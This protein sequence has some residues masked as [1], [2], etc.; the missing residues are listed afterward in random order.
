MSRT[1]KTLP[2]VFLMLILGSLQGLM[3][4]SIDMYLPA[5]P[6]I[7][8]ELAVSAGD[9][10]YTLAIFL[11]GSAIGQLLY[12]PITDA[13]GRKRPL[14]VG[15][16]LYCIG[17]LICASSSTIQALVIGR[18]VQAVGAAAT[19][20]I[21][22]AI[23]RDLWSG[24]EL[25]HRLS[26]LMMILGAAPILAPSLGGFILLRW[27]WHGLFW[28][29][30]AFGIVSAVAVTFLPETSS[31][32]SRTALNFGNTID[33][34]K[35]L[36]RNRRFVA[37]LL[38]SAAA[39]GMLLTYITSSSFIYIEL[40]GVTPSQF[41]LFFGINAC[42][43]VAASTLNRVLLKRFSLQRIA[44]TTVLSTIAISI[45]LIIGASFG[46]TNLPI[47][48][49]L[50][51]LLILSIGMVFPNLG[52]LTFGAIESLFGSASALSGMISSI[53]GGIAG[54]LVSAYSH[55]ALLPVTMIIGGFAVFG[56]V[57]FAVGRSAEHSLKH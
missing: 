37:Y 27:D 35:I 14:Y 4:I 54:A 8:R 49:G 18:F 25:A 17:T 45:V 32:E 16:V 42:G 47:L 3:P 46:L 20:V 6:T 57:M 13:F 15:F 29:L 22:S 56:A 43:I 24:A 41:A 19:G 30:T 26:T 40:L 10:Q 44:Q 28:F 48:S 50:F 39:G 12:G 36:L 21:T 51:F 53:I 2:N 34:F 52:A 38:T 33:S 5:M 11:F 31:P 55:G 23:A 9:V 1:A 7:A